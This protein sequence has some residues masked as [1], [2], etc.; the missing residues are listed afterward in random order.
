MHTRSPSEKAG[1]DSSVS[2]EA[3]SNIGKRIVKHVPLLYIESTSNVPP[4]EFIIY[5]HK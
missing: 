4:I 1:L 3:I 5:L 2:V